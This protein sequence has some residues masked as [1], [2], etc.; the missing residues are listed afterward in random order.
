MSYIQPT[1][2][3]LIGQA[4]ADIESRLPGAS[5]RTRRSNLN[6]F[7]RVMAALTKGLYGFMAWLYKQFFPHTA[8]EEALRVQASLWLDKPYIAATY[9]AGAVTASGTVASVIPAG[10][11]VQSVTGVT[12]SVIEDAEIDVAGEATVQVMADTPGIAGNLA[13]AA[14]LSL[15]LPIVGVNSSMTVAAGGIVGGTDDETIEALRERL[16]R[17]MQYT[18]MGGAW[19][20]YLS[21][22][23]ELPGVTRA[24]V[25]PKEL[26]PGSVTLRIMRDADDD[27][28]PSG[29]LLAEAQAYIS[30]R[31]NVTAEAVVVAPIADAINYTITLVPN[32]LAVRTAVENQLKNLHFTEASPGGVFIDPDTRLQKE[33]GT[34]LL[35]H[36]REAISQAA[37]EF[38]HVL[39]APTED[40]NSATGRIPVLG[41]ITWL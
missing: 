33:G 25:Y 38:D 15:V 34:L 11:V 36:I 40:I 21:W 8:D 24:W 14:V 18:P 4:Q 13:A 27:P 32:T 29:A 22:A 1:L 17:R 35:S 2:P 5:A 3:D 28:F 10:S 41:E 31:C 20:D 9:A 26:N 39:H 12:Y 6:V 19:Y 23:Y 7:A 16:I 30:D 37:G